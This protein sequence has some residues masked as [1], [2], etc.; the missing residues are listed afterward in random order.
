MKSKALLASLSLATVLVAT[1]AMAETYVI[2][3]EGAHASVNFKANHL[4]YSYVMGRFND[5]EGSFTY[6]EGNPGAS[7]VNVT[8]DAASV[9]TNHAERDKHLRSADF[10]EVETYPEITF[11]STA[12]T[13]QG[14]GSIAITGDLTMHGVTQSVVLEGEHVGHGEDPWGGYR[15][16]MEASTM[17]DAESFGFPAWLGDVEVIVIVEGIRQ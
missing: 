1:P 9:D 17:V 16:G 12:F 10:F 13:E 15:R 7:S 5:F 2:D 6:E 8:I 3:T 4:G 14:D 11:A